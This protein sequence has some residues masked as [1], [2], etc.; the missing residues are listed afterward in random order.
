MSYSAH[1]PYI[2]WICPEDRGQLSIPEMHIPRRL[3]TTIRSAPYEIKINTDFKGVIEGC[4]QETPDRPE[5]WINTPIKDVF[6]QL[7]QK[8]HAHSVECWQG[9]ELVGG[10]YGLSIG[11]AFFG[12]SMFSRARDA[13]KIA[14]IHLAARL[15]KGGY[16]L[17]DTQFVNNHIRQ[18]G[19]HEVKFKT[20][21]KQLS[22][23]IAREADFLLKGYKEG[24]T[25]L[26]QDYLKNR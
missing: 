14:L 1:S 18:F 6:I 4:A 20:Y 12:E 5:T 15:H 7:H 24:E 25:A 26:V 13:S 2:H 21:K 16:T 9:K 10:V 3:L 23:A 8:G 22:T 19:A 17:F 11:A